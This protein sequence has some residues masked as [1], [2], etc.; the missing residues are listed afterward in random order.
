MIPDSPSA[1]TYLT[2]REKKVARLRMR[3]ER[4]RRRKGANGKTSPAAAAGGLRS[5]ELFSVFL[6]PKAWITAAMFFLAN[7]AYSSLPVFLPT[8]LTEMGYSRLEAQGLAAPPYLLAFAAVLMTARAS[9][10][11]QQRA[12]F[13]AAHAT[14]SA[15]GYGFLAL[16][17]PLGLSPGLRYAAV[18]PAAIGFFNVVVLVI[19]W[20]V[21]NQPS[22]SRR[23][24][25]FALLQF[26]GQCG[27]LIGT[28]LYPARHAPFFEPGMWTCAAAM[29]A[30]ALLALILRF[31][32]GIVN[33]RLD[34]GRAGPAA[35][36]GGGGAGGE[37]VD[38]EAQGL[39]S[40]TPSVGDGGIG[41]L[42]QNGESGFRFML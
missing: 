7:M 30:V 21:N 35:E 29:L 32:L 31:Y 11:A 36:M 17:R 39:V 5:R 3:H 1:A 15:V 23:G 10:R 34:A 42:Q 6:D 27:P 9:D 25:G 8:I 41:P 12:P 16:A 40:G 19:A 26:V 24:G 38:E 14:A 4:P 2:A 33:R 37:P 18:Y 22:D 20:S 13:V 28:R